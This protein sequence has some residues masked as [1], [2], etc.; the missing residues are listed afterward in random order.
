MI[1]FYNLAL[2][3]TISIQNFYEIKRSKEILE[4]TELIIS[5]SNVNEISHN[6]D[7]N[8]KLSLNIIYR[9]LF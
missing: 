8:E 5:E 2:G 1:E 7:V 6:N 9:N 4:N 3:S